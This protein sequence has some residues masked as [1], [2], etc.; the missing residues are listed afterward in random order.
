MIKLAMFVLALASLGG[1]AV[2]FFITKTSDFISSEPSTSELVIPEISAGVGPPLPP[3]ATFSNNNHPDAE[4]IPLE[5]EEQIKLREELDVLRESVLEF[6]EQAATQE[7]LDARLASIEHQ[8][9][10]FEE[11]KNSLATGFHVFLNRIA[12]APP[13]LRDGESDNSQIILDPE[14]N[15]WRWIA[16]EID[17][18]IFQNLASTIDVPSTE[19]DLDF[20]LLAVAED[21]VK[22]LGLTGLFR[23]GSSFRT[24][25]DL[26]FSTS[27]LTL[28]F[29]GISTTINFRNLSTHSRVVSAPFV[30]A[31]SGR[32]FRF[33]SVEEFPIPQTTV[34]DNVTRQ[35][36]EYRSIGLTFN[37]TVHALNSE[38]RLNLVVET[39]SVTDSEFETAPVFRNNTANVSGKLAWSRWSLI[40]G[41]RVD[42][43]S[44]RKGIFSRSRESSS[45]LLLVFVRP[46]KEFPNTSPPP[47]PS[48]ESLG[49]RFHDHSLLPPF[50][51]S[52]VFSS[53]LR[54]LQA[55][56]VPD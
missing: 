12:P 24:L 20:V 26:G 2:F 52:S 22:E 32:P 8:E 48:H 39:G 11:R 44:T 14:S 31:V 17:T 25:F 6:E 54:P 56:P 42:S 49:L 28:G 29:D 19:L 34:V 1:I 47:L 5:S 35:S 43:G 4:P 27:G 13:V 53:G 18:A 15:S 40:G 23:D 10:Q 3:V 55:L 9:Q 7:A 36:F 30:R 33:E 37:G 41:L 16:N 51:S 46:R 21:G 50:P 38:L 45:D